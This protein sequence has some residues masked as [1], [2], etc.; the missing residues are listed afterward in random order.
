MG[1]RSGPI[2]VYLTN[3]G[4][5]TMSSSGNFAYVFSRNKTLYALDCSDDGCMEVTPNGQVRIGAYKDGSV[6]SYIPASEV[7]EIK[8]IVGIGVIGEDENGEV[9]GTFLIRIGVFYDPQ[10]RVFDVWKAVKKAVHEYLC[11]KQGRSL[12]DSVHEEFGWALFA[13]KIPDE[14]CRKYGFEILEFSPGDLEVKWE[15][16]LADDKALCNEWKS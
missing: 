1:K 15:G 9:L 8:T 7:I 3:A 2:P 13:E 16:H 14:I 10:R 11:T 12:Y 5:K 4:K 6:W